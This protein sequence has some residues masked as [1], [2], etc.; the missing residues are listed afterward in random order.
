MTTFQ[1]NRTCGL[2]FKRTLTCSFSC[3]L[4]TT[5]FLKDTDVTQFRKLFALK[6]QSVKY[7]DK[8]VCTGF[9]RGYCFELNVMKKNIL[10]M[11][12]GLTCGIKHFSELKGKRFTFYVI[13]NAHLIWFKC[14]SVTIVFL[15][16]FPTWIYQCFFVIKC[17]LGRE[18]LWFLP[19]KKKKKKLKKNVHHIFWYLAQFLND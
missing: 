5:T 10:C 14:T 1:A 8:Y 2:C 18:I 7:L 17:F 6:I 15:F 13:S 16:F 11:Q 12:C 19:C 3:F 4:R 9:E